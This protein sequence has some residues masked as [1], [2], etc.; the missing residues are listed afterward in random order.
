MEINNFIDNN[1]VDLVYQGLNSI[2]RTVHKLHI[3]RVLD[4]T[5]GIVGASNEQAINRILELYMRIKS[6]AHECVDIPYI[7]ALHGSL[8]DAIPASGMLRAQPMEYKDKFIKTLNYDD[9]AKELK[10]IS[11]MESAED[12]AIAY[13][14]YLTR[15]FLFKEGNILVAQLVATKVLDESGIGYMDI[16]VDTKEFD[17]IVYNYIV[18]GQD[19]ELSAY[20]KENCIK[21]CR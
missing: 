8:G 13:F 16:P 5:C 1:I 18:T 15:A 11:V 14:V 17:R 12:K 20:V 10:R 4:G 9:V 3:R 21:H 6:T 7:T 2:G 19:A